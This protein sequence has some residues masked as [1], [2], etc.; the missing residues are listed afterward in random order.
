M[1]DKENELFANI[2][3]ELRKQFDDIYIIGK[4]LSSEPPRFPA[5]SIIQENN[6]VNARYSTFNE[7]ENVACITQYIEIYSND[8]EQKEE[9]CKSISKVIDDVLKTHGYCR[10]LNQPMINV[11][12][13]IARRVMRYKKEIETQY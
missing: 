10:T 7:L 2:A 8:R 5:V 9:V 12:D 3:S 1:T 6:T 11:D 4:Q 13:S